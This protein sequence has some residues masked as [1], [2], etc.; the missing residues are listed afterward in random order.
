MLGLH[1]CP[2][3]TAAAGLIAERPQWVE[4]GP[5]LSRLAFEPNHGARLFGFC[6][7]LI[8]RGD[9]HQRMHHERPAVA[10]YNHKA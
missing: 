8:E 10:A 9:P 2:A 7:I 1:G 3:A 4:S 5:S 6:R